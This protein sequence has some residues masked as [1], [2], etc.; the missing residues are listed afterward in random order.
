MICTTV[1]VPHAREREQLPLQLFGPAIGVR[2]VTHFVL[3]GANE[4]AGYR[5]CI[6]TALHRGT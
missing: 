4:R 6:D 5:L 1:A 2:L 3:T